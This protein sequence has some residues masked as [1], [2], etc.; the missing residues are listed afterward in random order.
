[1]V[2]DVFGGREVWWVTADVASVRG[3]IHSDVVDAHVDGEGYMRKVDVAEVEGH[4]EVGDQI[5]REKY[6]E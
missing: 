1:M 3:L 4:P 6:C 5:L 2:F